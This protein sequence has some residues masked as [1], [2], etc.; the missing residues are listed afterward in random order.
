MEFLLGYHLP[1]NLVDPLFRNQLNRMFVQSPTRKSW[2]H[3][4]G[5]SLLHCSAFSHFHWNKGSCLYESEYWDLA[6]AKA[7][8]YKHALSALVREHK[9]LIHCKN[10][11]IADLLKFVL[12][13]FSFSTLSADFEEYGGC[14]FEAQEGLL[15]RWVV[16]F[17]M[18][19]LEHCLFQSRFA[20]E[21]WERWRS[22]YKTCSFVE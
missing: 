2:L 16:P 18:T 10:R 21:W 5:M 20:C 15:F 8:A 3:W 7:C 6:S 4:M 22:W 12:V 19:E 17:L 14:L 13:W 11:L 1:E 9:C